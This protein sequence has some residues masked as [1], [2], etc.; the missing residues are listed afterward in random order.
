MATP[1]LINFIVTI[2]EMKMA[3]NGT[4]TACQAPAELSVELAEQLYADD[5][6]AKSSK[7]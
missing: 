5:G 7:I 2:T 3:R 6:A 4:P 1:V